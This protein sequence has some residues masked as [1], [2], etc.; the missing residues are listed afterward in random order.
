MTVGTRIAF[1][2][3]LHCYV[4][5]FL[6]VLIS[7]LSIRISATHNI[8]TCNSFVVQYIR[9]T[10]NFSTIAAF[11]VSLVYYVLFYQYFDQ[12]KTAPSST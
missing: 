2:L 8:L 5:I 1:K 3:F 4:Q 11:E 7:Y 10:F 6:D 12:Y 9:K